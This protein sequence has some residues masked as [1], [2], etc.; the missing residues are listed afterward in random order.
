VA[1]I[2]AAVQQQ[3]ALEDRLAEIAAEHEEG[4]RVLSLLRSASPEANHS[5]RGDVSSSSRTGSATPPAP[6]WDALSRIDALERRT[7]E[8][9]DIILDLADELEE[10]AEQLRRLYAPTARPEPALTPPAQAGRVA[11]TRLNLDEYRCLVDRLR[12]VVCATVPAG[13]HVI[14]V[15]RGD[16]EL[17]RLDGRTSA[18][19][20][21]AERGG[22]AGHYPAD[23][24]A[25]VAHLEALRVGGAEYLV[26]PR[27]SMWWL[28]HYAD[29]RRH[30]EAHYQVVANDPQTC[31]IFALGRPSE[32]AAVSGERAA[33]ARY[34]ALR[35]QVRDVVKSILPAGATVIVVSRGDPE[36]LRLDGRRAWHFPQVA[37]G[38]YAGHAPANSADAIS[39]LDALRVQGGEYLLFP[40]TAF[41]W[42]EYY[43]GF[44][45]YLERQCRLVCRQE[46]VCAIYE[47]ATQ[48]IAPSASATLGDAP[49]LAV[50][51]LNMHEV[52]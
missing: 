44:R 8:L 18:H 48:T 17:L 20:P 19:F 36:L 5:T 22:Y 43:E 15:S 10:H 4:E 24:S 39:L 13:A 37:D 42:L 30:L 46:H 28:D 3:W 31:L 9:S 34:R 51:P 32:R 2:R 26:F 27:T 1:T 29:F 7:Q 35:G 12:Q 38:S 11:T 21:Q 50:A 14:V 47:L 40:S 52:T 25:A 49:H 6:P 41:W 23:S 33:D 16:D 45:E